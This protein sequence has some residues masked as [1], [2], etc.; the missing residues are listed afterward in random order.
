MKLGLGMNLICVAVNLAWVHMYGDYMFGLST[1]PE[2]AWK[3]IWNT[4][5]FKELLIMFGLQLG[6]YMTSASNWTKVEA[7]G[8]MQLE[9]HTQSVTAVVQANTTI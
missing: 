3:K 4:S 5:N 1:F 8:A 7:P 9:K 6:G 2:W